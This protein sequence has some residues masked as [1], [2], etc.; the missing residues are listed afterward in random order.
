MT[1][2]GGISKE[3]SLSASK[4]VLSFTHTWRNKCVTLTLSFKRTATF[5][6]GLTLRHLDGAINLTEHAQEPEH[7]AEGA[8]IL[9]DQGDGAGARGEDPLLHHRQHVVPPFQLL[10]QDVLHVH[11]P[12]TGGGRGK[13]GP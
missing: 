7:S 6:S 3:T 5:N 10:H 9:F 13:T 4:F 12:E 1:V 8:L 2:P 11:E